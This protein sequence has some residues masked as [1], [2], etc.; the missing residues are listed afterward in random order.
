MRPSTA[1]QYRD[2]NAEAKILVGVLLFATLGL[3]CYVCYA[4]LHIYKE[5]L[6]EAGLYLVAVFVVGWDVLRYAV[7]FRAEKEKVWPHAPVR[8]ARCAD[9]RHVQRAFEENAIVVG[10]DVF[11][12]PIIWSDEL[13][14]MQSN[15]F[16]MTGAG[17]TTL[18]LNIIQQDLSRL[19]G[20]EGNRHRVP[21]IIID[22]KAER[23]FLDDELLPLIAAA[24]RLD[25][26]RIIDPTRPEIS[27]RFNPFVAND[28]QYK[29]HVNFVFN[30]FDLRE[31]FFYGHQKT[32]L[33][34]I[35]RILHYTGKLYNMYD[36]LVMLYDLDILKEQSEIAKRRIETLAGVTH[37]QRLNFQMSVR[38]LVESFNDPKRVQMIR[39]LINN[40]M[41]FLEDRLSIITGPYEDLISIEEVIE[42]GQI[43]FVFLNTNKNDDNTALGRMILQNLQLIIGERYERKRAGMYMPF[44]SVI[45]D[46][47]APIAYSNFANILQ[48][49]RG[50]N[51]AFLFAMQSVPQLLTVGK[52]F[53]HD[54]SSAP[55]TT[56]M[57]R[58]RDEDTAQYFLQASARVRQL[59]RS[60]S[61]RK[62]GVFNPAYEDQGVG[63]QTEIKDTR[64]QE[65]HIKNLPVGQMEYLMSDKRFGTIH[66]HAHVRRA[67]VDRLA[68]FVPELLPRYASTY[69][70]EIGA[71]LRF[72]DAELEARRRRAMRSERQE[73]R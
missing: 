28:G 8:L 29:E 25:D 3:I 68:G 56:F 47:F 11:G 44:V 18:L 65:E 66:G 6:L 1:P 38:N 27:V 42:R 22:G 12:K 54:V 71:N 52:A 17:K 53:Q 26:L 40:M 62:T 49:A 45:M 63:S 34:D 23:Q 50:S 2:P 41:T 64:S 20:P 51:T 15:A 16:G 36:V 30:S 58:T 13:R 14:V 37:Q 72:R 7:T 69:N 39:G 35:V 61:I 10:Y 60:M 4:R 55:N 31:D 70:G 59:R 24:G 33:S 73:R 67:S 48:T 46:E 32:Y 21:L 19:A 9:Q 43:L 5:Q 57:L